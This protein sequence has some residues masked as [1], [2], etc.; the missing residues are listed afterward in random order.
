MPQPSHERVA[1]QRDSRS[2]A[3]NVEVI[4]QKLRQTRDRF[5]VGEVTRTDVAQSESRVRGRGSQRCDAESNLTASR[6]AFRR[7]IGIEP[8]HWARHA[9]RPTSPRTLDASQSR[10]DSLRKPFRHGRRVRR[11]CRANSQVKVNEGSLHPRP[12][13]V[14]GSMQ[15]NWKHTSAI[16]VQRQM[17]SSV[18]GQLDGAHLSGRS[19]IFADPSGE[20]DGRAAPARTRRSTAIRA[21]ANVVQVRDRLE[22]VQGADQRHL[23]TGYRRRN[24]AERRA[25]RGAGR[26]A[27]H[28][29]RAQRPAGTR[30]CA[31]GAGQRATR[32][33]RGVLYAAVGLR[34][35]VDPG[36]L[37]LQVPGSTIR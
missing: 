8:N 5:S 2:T 19:R 21:R 35:A 37:G 32:P 24:R 3:H 34:A 16:V 28:A 18:V 29:R 26:P 33:C 15:Q 23:V 12:A 11:R 17:V 22:A 31:C 25:G 36:V 6:A 30:E 1:R 13:T 4:Q 14:T 10:R 7:V 27:H 9:G 20:G